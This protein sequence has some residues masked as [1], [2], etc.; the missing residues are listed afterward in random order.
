MENKFNKTFTYQSKVDPKL[1]GEVKKSYTI[2]SLIDPKLFPDAPKEFLEELE[3]YNQETKFFNLVS[4]FEYENKDVNP[5]NAMVKFSRFMQKEGVEPYELQLFRDMFRLHTSRK[6]TEKVNQ[7]NEMTEEEVEFLTEYIHRKI[8]IIGNIYLTHPMDFDDKHAM[9]EYIYEAVDKIT[10]DEIEGGNVPKKYLCYAEQEKGVLADYFLTLVDEMK[11]EEGIEETNYN[12]N[13]DEIDN[14]TSVKIKNKE[15]IKRLLELWVAINDSLAELQ[16]QVGE[17]EL[18][19]E[20]E[21][22]FNDKDYLKN[23]QKAVQDLV[24]SVNETGSYIEDLGNAMNLS[25]RDW[26]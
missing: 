2:K 4:K 7:T 16:E 1:L 10:S 24:D 14:K 23:L 5:D 8:E 17:L 22:D 9:L 25:D 11:E 13:T 15:K 26:K 12:D 20:E 6:I 21:E 19:T 18:E 3:K